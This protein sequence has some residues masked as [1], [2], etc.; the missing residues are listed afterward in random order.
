M[1]ES[2]IF[3]N[4]RASIIEAMFNHSFLLK[5]RYYILLDL[6]KDQ[7]MLYNNTYRFEVMVIHPKKSNA[8][9]LF[10]SEAKKYE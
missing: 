7:T 10:L 6:G 8:M 9:E 1:K 4:I 5:I 2:T 3:I